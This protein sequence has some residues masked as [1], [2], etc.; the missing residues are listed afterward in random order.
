MLAINEIIWFILVFRKYNKR[1][2][3]EYLAICI[4]FFMVL[5]PVMRVLN[6]TSEEMYKDIFVFLIVYI[7]KYLTLEKLFGVN[8]NKTKDELYN[9]Y[10]LI[11]LIM[12]YDIANYIKK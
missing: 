5:I 3:A 12:I 8:Q 10:L 9:K 1:E 11:C 6:L 4:S 2:V 7:G